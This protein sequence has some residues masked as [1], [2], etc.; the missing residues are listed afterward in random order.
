MNTDNVSKLRIWLVDD[1]ADQRELVIGALLKT[2]EEIS[3]ASRVKNGREFFE[4]IEFD[5]A[6][7]AKTEL[8]KI[9]Y[10]SLPDFII[11]DNNFNHATDPD[12][13]GEDRGLKL[14]EFAK[15]EFPEIPSALVTQYEINRY[16]GQITRLF[17]DESIISLSHSI[18]VMSKSAG[19]DESD[20]LKPLNDALQK[21]T[22]RILWELDEQNRTLIGSIIHRGGTLEELLDLKIQTTEGK[23]FLLKSLLAPW[24]ELIYDRVEE[25]V[26]LA[27]DEN[28]LFQMLKVWYPAD[29][30]RPQ[31][32]TGQL[33]VEYN[34][35]DNEQARSL[36]DLVKKFIEQTQ[37]EIIKDPQTSPR[38]ALAEEIIRSFFTHNQR[39]FRIADKTNLDE[40]TQRFLL[41]NNRNEN[42]ILSEFRKKAMPNSL[43]IKTDTPKDKNKAH[44]E[45][46]LLTRLVIIG[47]YALRQR[48][49]ILSNL[50]FTID[51]AIHCVIRN[52]TEDF[53][54]VLH[55]V[56]DDFRVLVERVGRVRQNTTAYFNSH[57]GLS[58]ARTTGVRN[59]PT[60]YQLN[61]ERLDLD[62]L[63]NY[64][65]D[66]W[67]YAI[68]REQR[69]KTLIE[70]T[71]PTVSNGTQGQ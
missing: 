62:S 66:N 7:K 70:L 9:P 14:L 45:N 68:L 46:V 30:T 58:G 57:C 35:R 16:W 71:P 42:R 48:G 5:S 53:L 40:D 21:I 17:N 36:K 64:E 18:Y 69:L 25:R 28:K 61:E 10:A 51:F 33:N 49:A 43:I 29:R 55:E 44:W 54:A 60:H 4:I 52:K 47:I 8:E 11:A 13:K 12:D 20:N 26:E 41:Q 67:Y 1:L 23:R 6:K 19:F 63:F 22:T 59:S 56:L 34:L 27:F 65:R 2:K 38:L 39:W 15:R 31:V 3:K 32:F 24:G 50:P 37:K